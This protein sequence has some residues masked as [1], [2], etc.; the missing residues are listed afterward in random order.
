VNF[1]DSNVSPSLKMEK[2]KHFDWGEEGMRGEPL[3]P[4][5]K[6]SVLGEPLVPCGEPS[7]L[8]EPLVPCGKPS[9]LNVRAPRGARPSP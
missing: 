5:G 1:V 2:R 3:V 4:C 8:G 7:V 6:P 9:E